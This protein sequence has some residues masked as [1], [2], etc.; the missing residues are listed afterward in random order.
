MASLMAFGSIAGWYLI[1]LAGSAIV[2]SSSPFL[3][4]Q[5][6]RGFALRMALLGP[7]NF[8]AAVWFAIDKAMGRL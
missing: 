7:I 1:G 2:L 6:D 8:T 4:W 5:Q 3:T